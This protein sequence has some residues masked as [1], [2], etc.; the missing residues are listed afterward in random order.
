MG[1]RNRKTISGIEDISTINHEFMG[2]EQQHLKNKL[3]KI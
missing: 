3:W 1:P 2:K